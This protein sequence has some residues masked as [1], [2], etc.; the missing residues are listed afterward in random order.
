MYGLHH[1][2]VL[3]QIELFT[4]HP[5]DCATKLINNQADIGLVPVAAI[6]KIEDA[7]IISDFCISAD[8]NV[9][10]VLLLSEVPLEEIEIIM[11]DYQSIT[12][13]NL[14]K[15]LA[16]EFWNIN[17]SFTNAA[18]GFESLI[19]GTNAAVVI[20]DRALKIQDK[21]QYTYDLAGEWKKFCGLPFVFAC[22][23]SNKILTPDFITD[24]NEALS[25]GVNNLDDVIEELRKNGEYFE[26]VENYLKTNLSYNFSP[27]KKKAMT[28]FLSYLKKMHPDAVKV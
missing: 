4:D 17:P 10:S 24:F 7:I 1:H 8:D 28:L 20:G 14:V 19:S 3:K 21:F 16:T 18:P 23:V 9:K 6:P 2:H 26:G 22:W 11:L 13:V 12:S 15:V 27:D 5:A 25:I